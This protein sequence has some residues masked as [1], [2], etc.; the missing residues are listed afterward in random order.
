M[1]QTFKI[2]KCG[3]S[4][5]GTCQ[6]VYD[7]NF[8]FSNSTKTRF[9]PKLAGLSLLNC[10]TENIIYLISCKLCQFQYVGETKNRLQKRFSGHKNSIK[11]GDSGQIVHKHFQEDGHGLSNCSIIPIE[12][13]NTSA[14]NQQ[15]LSSMDL[16]RAV[17]K[18]RL[19]REKYWISL[20]QT[21]YP[22]GLNCRVK[23]V[24]D[25]LPSQGNFQQFG[26]RRRRRKKKH[27]RRKP[28]RLRAKNEVSLDFVLRKHQELK[29]KPDYVHFFKGC[30]S[31]SCMKVY[32]A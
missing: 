19:E 31:I 28:K 8:F 27:S 1:D 16:D 2:K 18:L 14:I 12:K 17:N 6:F 7:C 29:N 15:G 23:G 22:F 3:G 32:T 24:G 4:R 13:I 30:G 21:A 5:C 10:K 26:G 9:C 25:F 11:K 20:L